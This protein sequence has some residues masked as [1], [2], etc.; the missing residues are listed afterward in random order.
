[1]S[2]LP[3]TDAWLRGVI[4]T[5]VDGIL[6]IDAEG[7][8]RLFNKAAERMFGYAADE[9]LGRNVKMLMPPPFCDEHDGYLL[10]YLTSREPRIIGIGRDVQGRRADG[11][12]FPM[13]LSVGEIRHEGR[14]LFAG[15]I[16]DITRQKKDEQQLREQAERLRS[17]LETVP[18]AIIIINERGLIESFSPA[19]ERQFGW[20][21]TEVIGRNVNILM[22]SPYAEQ[23][24]GYIERYR[25]TGERRII[26]IGRV[27]VGQRRN[28]S[29]FPMELAVGEMNLSGR[30]LFTG[31]V[32]DLT[33][34]Q[35]RENRLQ[36]VHAELL[37]VSRLSDMG[38]MASAL[39][40]E[41]NQP[42]TAVV[43]W[44]QAARRMIQT[45]G[46]EG[47]G[48]IQEFV[49]KSIEQANRAG[50]IIRRLRSFVEKG[51]T[52]RGLEEPNK[53]VEEATALA[54]VGAREDGVSISFQLA[55]RLPPV[56]I[57]R[58]QVQQVIVNLVRNGIEAMGQSERREL[59]I[60]TALD[61]Q[62][63]VEIAVSD[64]GPGIAPEVLQKL[65]QPFVTTKAKGMGIGL[66]IC[67][68]II[69]HH[70]GRLTGG[71]GP[72][73]GAQFVFTLPPAPRDDEARP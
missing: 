6:I 14:S 70:G 38:Q 1:M 67:H 63:L 5:A 17:I 61:G 54:L 72:L 53:V 30:R 35:E 73:G 32:R 23:H 24:D 28:G 13:H 52:E 50:Q 66:S 62:G 2:E 49:E 33:E 46:A 18:D 55:E 31:F 42:L 25:T 48:K 21:A 51:E 4:E 8:V 34:A 7:S 10:R 40:H 3:Q 12:V 44:N 57:D 29:T 27:V 65:F 43:N 39:A 19:A 69:E 47:L 26:G 60:R 71:P 9:V 41:L 11:S 68:A 15:I 36:D 45:R 16:H 64:S 37:H 20:P 22:P 58:V 59:V 56:L